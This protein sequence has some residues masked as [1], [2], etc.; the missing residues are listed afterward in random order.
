MSNNEGNFKRFA[1]TYSSLVLKRESDKGKK[2]FHLGLKLADDTEDGW[3]YYK[4]FVW[5]NLVNY[6]H[7]ASRFWR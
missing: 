1:I 6:Q 2:F 4:T 7:F 5:R 3:K